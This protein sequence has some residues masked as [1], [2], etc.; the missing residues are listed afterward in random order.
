MNISTLENKEKRILK[1]IENSSKKIERYNNSK[2]KSSSTNSLKERQKLAKKEVELGKVRKDL[3][4]ERKR[5]A[6]KQNREQRKYFS[7]LKKTQSEATKLIS[8]GVKINQID[9]REF[10]IFISYV[11][12]DSDEY[13]DRL[14]DA[15][16]SREIKTFRDKQVIRV[17]QS[18]RQSMDNALAKSKFAIVV[19]SPEYLT[20]YWT[21]YEIDGILTKESLTGDQM[22]LPIWHGVTADEIASK[23]PSLANKLAWNSSLN[24][25]LEIVDQIEDL[26][27]RNI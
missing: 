19:F 13:V 8:S 9:I 2:L 12:L 3:S 14:Y 22:I 27:G 17:G 1:D 24:T 16:M 18:L 4:K 21:N 7:D 20:K 15:L 5:E 23:S 6:T 26:L 11:Q 25:T 10:D